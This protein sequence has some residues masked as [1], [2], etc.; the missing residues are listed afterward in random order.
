[1]ASY[2]VNPLEIL[3]T[4]NSV[5]VGS[6]GSLTV[7]GGVSVGRDMYIGGNI[8][9]K[10]TSASFADNMLILNSGGV[11]SADTGLLLH[12]NVNDVSNNNNYSA[13]IYN[14]TLDEFMFG[15]A[16]SDNH[17]VVNLNSYVPIRTNGVNVTGGGLN[18]TFNS[19]TIGNIFTTGGNVGIKTTSPSYVLDVNGDIHFTGEIYKSGNLYAGSSQWLYSGENIYYSGNVG[20]GTTNPSERLHALGELRVDDTGGN[21]SI[22][23]D[24]TSA[25]PR[26]RIGGIGNTD[27]NFMVMGA[28]NNQ[29][30]IDTKDRMLHI[31]NSA[32][33]TLFYGTTSGNV[34]IGNTVPAYTLDV[35]GTANIT[36]S[37]TTGALFSTNITAT[38]IVATN[39]SSGTFTATNVSASTLD[40][41]TGATSAAINVTGLST[42][43]TATATNVSAST[44]DLSTGATSA[45]INVTGLSTLQTVTATNVSAATADLSTGATIAALNIPSSAGNISM[46]QNAINLG[47]SGVVYH[48]LKYDS[49]PNGPKIWGWGGGALAYGTTGANTVLTWNTAGS[50]GIGTTTTSHR[51]DVNGTA[52]I[53]TS[54]TTGAVFS[55][56]VTSTNIVAT[57][58]STG[59]LNL[60]SLI[61][62]HISSGTLDLSTGATSAALK[63]SNL[64]T[65]NTVT[66]SDVTVANLLATTQMSTG[67]LH[68]NFGSFNT[69]GTSLMNVTTISGGSAHFSGDINVAGTLTVVNITST[70]LVDTNVSAGVVLASTSFSATGTSNTLAN[71]FTT[72]GNVGIN[73]TDPQRA[74][75]I[76]G[77]LRTQSAMENI[78]LSVTGGSY[79]YMNTVAV[80]ETTGYGRIGT[81]NNDGGAQN[82]A[83]APAGGNVGINTTA[84]EYNLDV[85]GTF[86]ATTSVTTGALFSTNLTSTNIVATALSTGS[87]NLTSLIA[88][89]ISS[90][91]LDLSTGMT[92]AAINVTGLSTL[93]GVTATNISAGVVIASTSF[94]AFGNSNTM[95]SI[96][97]TGGNVGIGT[98]LP[99][100]K[101]Y[102]NGTFRG[103][104][105]NAEAWSSTHVLRNDAGED[106]VSVLSTFAPNLSEGAVM[107]NFFGKALSNGNVGQQNFTYIG[108]NNTGNSMSFSFFGGGGG[109]L[110]IK[111]NGY[112]DV[113]NLST[114]SAYASHISSGTLDLSTGATS[115]AINVTG[116]STL[117]TVTATHVSAATMNISTGIT[118]GTLMANTVDITPSLGDIGSERSATTGNGVVT[119]TNIPNFAF[120][121]AIVRGFNAFATVTI[122]K[123]AGENLYATYELKGIQKGNLWQLNS[124]Y[125][126]DNT[127][128]IFSIDT[129]GNMAYTSSSIGNF[130]SGTIK[131]KAMTTSV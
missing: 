59:S 75:D 115:A 16:T 32:G 85:N 71:I 9:V 127:G 122:A 95:G 76:V 14:E 48:G 89:H 129:S 118:S 53:T 99:G 73:K 93:Q 106:G 20:I 91:T 119:A 84:P 128:V 109:V 40:L 24:P 124:T 23:L 12:R 130:T 68:A 56:N 131:F 35:N 33:N 105:T 27:G 39:I 79:M 104:A 43:Q 112:V 17:G 117:Q 19:N 81:Y 65:L 88:S 4:S 54:L 83:L 69:V 80:N 125:I 107:A 22:Y 55:T 123:S 110:R 45:A 31:F 90:G 2:Q 18:A 86:R 121:N 94:S 41:S 28:Y 26:I 13:F 47:L 30:N 57:A 111:N 38:N 77:S 42:L 96:F 61:A 49:I 3:D 51:L 29:N 8:S 108:S 58:L 37:L 114:G 25:G 74:L 15:Y 82:L 92:S 70:N 72:G 7:G 60:T 103:D 66:A 1:M 101:L 6:G 120:S 36:T 44:L 21:N 34:G 100:Y 113:T 62:S 78:M 97:T 50:V 116:L 5:G 98:T 10:G 102:V 64:S 46:N 52:R 67:T 87:L 63:V 11:V 126:G